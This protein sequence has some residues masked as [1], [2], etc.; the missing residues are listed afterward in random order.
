LA[1]FGDNHFDG[2][3]LLRRRVIHDRAREALE[4]EAQFQASCKFVPKPPPAADERA[5]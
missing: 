2:C 4:A 1:P 5:N 3:D